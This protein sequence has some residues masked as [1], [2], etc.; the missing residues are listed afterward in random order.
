MV[1]GTWQSPT[2]WMD[3]LVVLKGAPNLENAKLFLNFMMDPENAAALTNFARY[4]AGVEGTEPYLDAELASAYEL[5]PPDDAPL[6]KFVP[7][8]EEK[9]V[10][11]YD[12]I[13]TNLLR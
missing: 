1:E 5:N 7:P 10:R 12:R 9:V 2:A 6:P 3:N 11:L 4:T 8:C 13:W